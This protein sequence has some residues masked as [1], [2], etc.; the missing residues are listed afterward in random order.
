MNDKPGIN[1]ESFKLTLNKEYVSNFPKG[2]DTTYFE[3]VSNPV[4]HRYQWYWKLLYY[5]TFGTFFWE[6]YTY[7]VKIKPDER[8][9]DKATNG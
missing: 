1:G 5:L 8:C 7:D 9:E 6:Y 2:I 4:R 3:I